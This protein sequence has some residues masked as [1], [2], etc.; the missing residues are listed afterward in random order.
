MAI[1][2]QQTQ[3]EVKAEIKGKDNLSRIGTYVLTVDAGTEYKYYIARV[4]LTTQYDVH[5]TEIVNIELVSS[6][7]I[8]TVSILTVGDLMEQI[9]KNTPHTPDCQK[10]CQYLPMLDG[11]LQLNNLKEKSLT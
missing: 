3:W 11:F 8:E 7:E 9:L 10:L 5:F 2:I 1:T 4:L 6:Q